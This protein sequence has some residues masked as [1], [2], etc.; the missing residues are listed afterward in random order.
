MGKICSSESVWLNFSNTKA[1]NCV[2][3]LNFELNPRLM[4]QILNRNEY[5]LGTQYIQIVIMKMLDR[6]IIDV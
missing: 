4:V 1:N 6:L 3:N 2:S 5:C